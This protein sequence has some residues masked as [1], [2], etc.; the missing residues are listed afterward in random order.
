MPE[1]AFQRLTKMEASDLSILSIYLDVRPQATG[2]NPALRA[3]L[4]LLKD[5]LCEIE[6]TLDPRGP[7]L[8]S[9]RSDTVAIE[10]YFTHMFASETHGLAI[11]ACA[12]RNLFEIVEAGAPF[13]DH[14]AGGPAPD[15]FQF[16]RL[17]DDQEASVVA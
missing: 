15:L 17:L 6:K 13:E 5:R 7:A 9:F 8:D 2:E 16:G 11:F 4:V 3:G 14:V 10:E 1:T 12:G